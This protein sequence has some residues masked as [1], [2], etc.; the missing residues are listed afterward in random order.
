[1]NVQ[2][3]PRPKVKSSGCHRRCRAVC[4]TAKP[5]GS[6][7]S[8][9]KSKPRVGSYWATRVIKVVRG[10][11]SVRGRNKPPSQKA[12][13]R[14]HAQRRGRRERAFAQLKTWKVLQKLRCCPF[15]A[16]LIVRAIHV[17]HERVPA[18]REAVLVR[19]TLHTPNVAG[20][21]PK[22]GQRRKQN[23]RLLVDD[24]IEVRRNSVGDCLGRAVD[25]GHQSG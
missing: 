6:D 16:G 20:N 3:S 10:A 18:H 12:A 25:A 1:M 15:K 17:H 8:S 21:Q 7:E 4:T 23:D 19:A 13:N 9:T 11:D 2:S 5:R 22:T 14:A 24:G